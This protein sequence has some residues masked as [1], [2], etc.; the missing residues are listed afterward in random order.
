VKKVKQKELADFF[1]LTENT[2]TNWKRNK[3]KQ[4][5]FKAI[6]LFYLAKKNNEIDK[7]LSIL[8]TIDNAIEMLNRDDESI[9]VDGKLI[10]LD[11]VGKK[12]LIKLK[13]DIEEIINDLKD[14]KK[15][16][17]KI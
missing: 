14:C 6:K 7:I 4:N 1:E 17:E 16:S 3:K 8:Q 12:R 5:L 13:S 9:K 10:S 15:A 2:M 11:E